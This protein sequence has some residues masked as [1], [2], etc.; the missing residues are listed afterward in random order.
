[1]YYSVQK[2]KSYGKLA[3]L[4]TAG[5]IH[6]VRIDNDEYSKDQ[7]ADF[8]LWKA[9]D[10]EADGENVWEIHIGEQVLK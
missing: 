3:H 6:S 7:I 10:A 9:Y 4:D 8:A 5:M 2:F 1:V